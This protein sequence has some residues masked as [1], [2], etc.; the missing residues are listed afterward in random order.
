MIVSMVPTFCVEDVWPNVEGHVRRAVEFAMLFATSPD[1]SPDEIRELCMSGDKM[2][3][4]V[5]DEETRKIEAALTTRIEEKPYGNVLVIDWIGG[6][7]VDEWASD[8]LKVMEKYA[9]EY[10]CVALEGAGRVGWTKIIGKAGWKPAFVVYRKE[11]ADEQGRRE[12]K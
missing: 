7:R 1:I 10:E 4:I 2:L 11:L 3:W 9:K 12:D 8:V 6:N 5:A